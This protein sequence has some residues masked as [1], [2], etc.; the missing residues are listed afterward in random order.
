KALSD[1]LDT[2]GTIARTVPDA[3]LLAAAVSGRADLLAGRPLEGALRVGI[4]RTYEW[5]QAQPETVAAFGRAAEKLAAAGIPVR[6]VKLPPTYANLVQAQSNIQLVEQAQSLAH[7]RLKYGPQLSA[8]LRGILEAGLR[9]APERYDAAQTLARNCRR[10]LTEVFTDCDVLLAPSAP[11]AAPEG[12]DMT[13]DPLFSRIWTLLRVPCVNIP[14][15]AAANGL[16]VGLQVIGAFG[17][18][19]QTL[20]A[21]HRLH[22][23]VG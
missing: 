13:G 20:A 8:R 10:S 11:G 17:N 22:Q 14:V 18:D 3:A 15:A 4:C 7:E 19:A 6:E 1:T 2:V 23:V 12:L 21:A 5:K 16:P 9:I